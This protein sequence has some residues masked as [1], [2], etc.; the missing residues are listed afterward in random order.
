M[1]TPTKV[2][3]ISG[4]PEFLPAE[5][6]LELHFLDVIQFDQVFRGS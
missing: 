5:R 2:T 4:F 3:P 1:S 6:L